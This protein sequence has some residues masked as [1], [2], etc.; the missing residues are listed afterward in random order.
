MLTYLGKLS[1]FYPFFFLLNPAC[2]D[3]R[4]SLESPVNTEGQDNVAK[5]EQAERSWHSQ[6][7]ARNCIFPI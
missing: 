2:V 1:F 6:I 4:K 7:Y 5:Q 3:E